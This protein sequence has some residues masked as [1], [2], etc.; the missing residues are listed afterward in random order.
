MTFPIGLYAIEYQLQD[1]LRI[2]AM[3]FG[4]ADSALSAG[5]HNF[6]LVGCSQLGK[7]RSTAAALQI[8]RQ[9]VFHGGAATS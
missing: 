2:L 1:I 3:R 9:R 4:G 5:A 6:A 7:D 8:D